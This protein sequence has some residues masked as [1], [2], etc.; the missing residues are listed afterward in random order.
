MSVAH[1]RNPA[2]S[3]APVAVLT[4]VAVTA[5][6]AGD[7][8]PVAGLVVD[9]HAEGAQRYNAVCA[10]VHV[11][12]VLGASE[13]A[14]LTLQWQASATSGGTYADVGPAFAFPAIGDGDAGTYTGIWAADLDLAQ[15]PHRYVRLV[16][17]I[18][19]SRSAT[20][21]ATLGGAGFFTPEVRPA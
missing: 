20:D 21:V 10:I 18:T 2:F 1:N 19:L 17:T 7:G 12:A 9:T 14:Q 5:G 8:D 11:S 4:G 15:T 6:A 13:T 16:R 3:I